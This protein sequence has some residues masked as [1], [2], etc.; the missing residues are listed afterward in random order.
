M[1]VLNAI[2]KEAWTTAQSSEV[3][4]QPGCECTVE[5]SPSRAL[6]AEGLLYIQALM[7]W[8]MCELSFCAK[9]LRVVI[10]VIAPAAVTAAIIAT[11]I[12]N[13]PFI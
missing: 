4:I 7:S 12:A 13:V 10:V 11:V 9:T 6:H 2:T 8:S 1:V 3:C 5:L